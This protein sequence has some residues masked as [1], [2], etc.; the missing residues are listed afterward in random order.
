[1]PAGSRSA[2]FL[3]GDGDVEPFARRGL[4]MPKPMERPTSPP[5]RKGGSS[6]NSRPCRSLDAA[7]PRN[8]SSV[9]QI[10]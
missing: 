4:E 10:R 9:R 3:M 2:S 8:H 1:M 5:A 7:Q 6:E